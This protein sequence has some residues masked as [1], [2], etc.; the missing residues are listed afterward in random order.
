MPPELIDFALRIHQ[1]DY[2][3]GRFGVHLARIRP[4][5]A[6]DIAR[7][8]DHHHLESEADTE[9]RNAAF[10]SEAHGVDFAFNPAIAKAARDN[11]AIN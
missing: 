10:A 1:V 5:E 2:R 7:V 9:N 6:Q 11:D 8:L 4:L 3:I